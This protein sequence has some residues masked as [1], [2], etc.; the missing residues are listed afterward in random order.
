MRLARNADELEFDVLAASHCIISVGL[1]RRS[2]PN[3]PG[4]VTIGCEVSL[5]S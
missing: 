1:V 5:L 4:T 3:R 2:P